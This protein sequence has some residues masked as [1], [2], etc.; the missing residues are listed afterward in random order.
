MLHVAARE[1][2]A[3]GNDHINDFM[4]KVPKTR[5]ARTPFFFYKTNFIRT[6]ASDFSKFKNNLRTTEPQIS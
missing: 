2:Q 5:E 6:R 4:Q 1:G 3:T